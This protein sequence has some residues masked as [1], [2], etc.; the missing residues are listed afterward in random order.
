[1]HGNSFQRKLAL[2]KNDGAAAINASHFL[3]LQSF[4]FSFFSELSIA[5]KHSYIICVVGILF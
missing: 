1:M 4:L 2:V 5:L 3:V